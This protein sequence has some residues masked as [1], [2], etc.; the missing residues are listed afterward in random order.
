M[1]KSLRFV[2]CVCRGFYHFGRALLALCN[3]KNL[4]ALFKRNKPT[5]T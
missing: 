3:P 2:W 5:P 1:L 4:K